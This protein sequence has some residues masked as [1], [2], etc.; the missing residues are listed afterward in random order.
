MLIWAW[1]VN[2][3]LWAITLTIASLGIKFLVK[4]QRELN[5]AKWSAYASD[6]DGMLDSYTEIENEYK[7][8]IEQTNK[9]IS[10]TQKILEEEESLSEK[11]RI[12]ITEGLE[13]QLKSL[14]DLTDSCNRIMKNVGNQQSGTLFKPYTFG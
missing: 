5:K 13:K 10:E 3:V 1:V 6:Y 4:G 7:G 11:L 9:Q 8:S 14:I 12:E 2:S